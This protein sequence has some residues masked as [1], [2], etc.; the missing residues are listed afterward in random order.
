MVF[1]FVG[2]KILCNA[3][4]KCFKQNLYDFQKEEHLNGAYMKWGM[5]GH[6]LWEVISY[7]S[8]QIA[9][10]T[11]NL[12]FYHVWYGNTLFVLLEMAGVGGKPFTH[13]SLHKTVLF[14]IAFNFYV[15]VS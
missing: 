4:L 11:R 7:C 12:L 1:Y 15:A 5:C 10:M 6:N 3:K 8:L 13:K 9:T 2:I 14:L